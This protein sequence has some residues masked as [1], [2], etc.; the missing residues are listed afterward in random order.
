MKISSS[1]VTSLFMKFNAYYKKINF[2]ADTQKWEL[3][4]YDVSMKQ[5]VH[6]E[7]VTIGAD[8]LIQYV[9]S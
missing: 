3:R 6:K 1:H 5:K 9:V 2:K 7:M 4:D 8:K